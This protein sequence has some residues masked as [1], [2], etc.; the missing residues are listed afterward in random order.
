MNPSATKATRKRKPASRSVKRPWG[1]FEQYAL[2]EDCT[3]SLMTVQPGKRLSLQAHAGRAELWVV[4]DD[5]AVVQVGESSRERR[6][7]DE[8]WIPA[9]AKHRL[10]CV[11][12]RP[13]RVLEIAFGSWRQADITRY[14]DDFNRPS[15]GE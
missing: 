2:N 6:A 7:G 14:A 9:R 13:V 4:L 12:R 1:S 8:I 15:R 11:G 3:V 10:G 5:G